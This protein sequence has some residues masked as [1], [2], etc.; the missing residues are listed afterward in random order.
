MLAK[1]VITVYKDYDDNSIR[2]IIKIPLNQIAAATFSD[3]E[4][5]E[6]AAAGQSG[7][8][9][10]IIDTLYMIISRI[11]RPNSPQGSLVESLPVDISEMYVDR[12]VTDLQSRSVLNIVKFL[13]KY[14]GWDN[15]R[16]QM[17]KYIRNLERGDTN[18]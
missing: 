17:D 2:Y 5:K 13:S 4:R 3:K 11:E 18:V 7:R 9:S 8:L 6:M 14:C 16:R 1:P 15:I 12:L 10:D